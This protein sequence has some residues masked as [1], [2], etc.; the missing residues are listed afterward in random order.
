MRQHKSKVGG[1][2]MKT[3]VN[4]KKVDTT[5][6]VL[7][8]IPTMDVVVFPQI[9]VPL[10]VL[11][12]K[13]IN[14]INR[15]IEEKKM[16]FLLAAKNG[17]DPQGAIST[18]DLHEIGTIA[19]VMRLIKL[20]EGGIKILVQGVCKARAM[21]IMT[22]DN[23]L[24]AQVNRI[25]VDHSNTAELTACVQK[26]KKIADQMATS[27]YTF[28]PDFHIILSKMQDPNKIGDFILSHLNLNVDDAQQL[29]ETESQKEFLLLLSDYLGK[30]VQVAEIQEKIR[31]NAR[32]SM[33]RSQKEFYLRE[34]LKAIKQELGEDDCE[35]IE[36]MREKLDALD[37]SD[38]VR[39]EVLRQ[40]NRLER[41][42]PDS[43]EAT[44]TRNHLEWIFSLP[45]NVATEDN[46]SIQHAQQILDEDH[47]GLKEIKDRILDFISIRNLKK[48]GYA[49]ILCFVGPPGTGKTSLGQI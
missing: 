32:E 49:P 45:W 16:V 1:G 25:D 42:A 2:L 35:E 40:I 20:P 47:F 39:K 22:D 38:E 43:L 15:A 48:D 26:I 33:N 30:E 24:Q 9:I 19:S 23:I 4:Q 29:L 41:T 27:G 31:N 37:L 28:S 34:Q 18:S 7:S 12:E 10:L 21:T 6:E 8:V 36:A 14:G 13:I 5:P 11:D 17:V 44:V 46:L 3:V